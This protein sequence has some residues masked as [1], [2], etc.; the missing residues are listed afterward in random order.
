MKIVDHKFKSHQIHPDTETLVIGTFN[1][2]STDN[3]ADFF[4]GRSRNN[5]WRLI[6]LALNNESL[7]EKTRNEK[8]EFSNKY[9]LDFIDLI[10]SVEVDNGQETNYDDS[11]IDSRVKEWVDIIQIVSNLK[12]IKRVCFTRKT[13][14]DIPK[15]KQRIIEIENFCKSNNI[16]FSVLVTPARFYSPKKQDVWNSFFRRP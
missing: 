10:N 7:K 12:N 9:K 15:M 13:L 16:D 14:S 1:P 8:I 11:Y 4:Y 5:L 6:P 3:P 2:N